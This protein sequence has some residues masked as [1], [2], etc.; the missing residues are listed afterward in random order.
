MRRWQHSS[1]AQFSIK[2]PATTSANPLSL[3]PRAAW[4]TSAVNGW[5]AAHY[6]TIVSSQGGPL[7]KYSA[8]WFRNDQSR[9]TTIEAHLEGK[10]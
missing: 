7:K 9:S 10:D 1:S 5:S 3:S 8:E 6:V 2:K 4:S